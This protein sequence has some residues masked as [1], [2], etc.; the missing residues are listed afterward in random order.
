MIEPR[1]YLFVPVSDEPVDSS[2]ISAALTDTLDISRALSRVCC[3]SILTAPVLENMILFQIRMVAIYPS[4][5]PLTILAYA[6]VILLG[7]IQK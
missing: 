4:E 6:S 5:R 3:I 7:D 1:Y 2:S